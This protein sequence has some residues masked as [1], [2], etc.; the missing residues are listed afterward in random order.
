[1]RKGKETIES[2][3]KEESSLLATPTPTEEI[4][5]EGDHV[6][7]FQ[8]V[9]VSFKERYKWTLS[10]GERNFNVA[11]HDDDFVR[12]VEEAVASVKATT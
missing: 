4:V 5:H 7:V 2:I 6:A 8:V 12:K 1:M 9:R 11:V 3:S 10:D